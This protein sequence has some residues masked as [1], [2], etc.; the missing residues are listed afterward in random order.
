MKKSATRI[1]AIGAV[2]LASL[3]FQTADAAILNGTLSNNANTCANAIGALNGDDC[4]YNDNWIQPGNGSTIDPWVGPGPSS[5]FYSSSLANGV[6]TNEP[7]PGDGKV[8]PSVSANITIGGGNLV[9][10]TITVGPVAYHNFSAGPTGRGEESFTSAV[11][12]LTPK[13]ADHVNGNTLIIGSAGFPAYLL[14]ADAS[15]Q[16]PSETGADSNNGSPDILWWAGPEPSGIGITVG[17]GNT[18]TTSSSHVVSGWGCN[19]V[20]GNALTGACNSASTW[21]NRGNFENILLKIVTDGA[22]TALS[23]EG[24]LV[25][26][27]TGTGTTDINGAK[28]GNWV[29]WTF[30]TPAVIPIPAAAWLFGS[31]LGLVGLMR[32]K[33]AAA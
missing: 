8:N 28:N 12:T 22:G 21:R 25:Q 11:I 20:D 30:S 29:A 23:I 18:G 27:N 7:T 32:R 3:A 5:G 26:G 2:G 6:W 16:F 17:E 19:D 33:V 31:A 4:S 9:S 24:F 14:A 13:A 15:D 10:G 1:A